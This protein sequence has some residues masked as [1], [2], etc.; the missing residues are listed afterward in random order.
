MIFGNDGIIFLFCREINADLCSS[1]MI[2]DY[3]ILYT[4]CAGTRFYIR[5]TVTMFSSVLV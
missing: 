2:N 4:F 1:Y 5:I 3:N